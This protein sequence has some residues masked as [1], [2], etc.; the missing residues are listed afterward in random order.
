MSFELPAIRKLSRC[1]SAPDAT[2]IPISLPKEQAA[3]I[4]IVVSVVMI[5]V[6]SIINSSGECGYYLHKTD[7]ALMK[8]ENHYTCRYLVVSNA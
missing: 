6:F 3:K 4:N 8:L 7:Q 5:Q 2:Y 1:M